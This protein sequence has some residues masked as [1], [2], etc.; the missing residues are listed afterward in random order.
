MLRFKD[1]INVGLFNATFNVRTFGTFKCNTECKG[2]SIKKSVWN[3]IIDSGDQYY[4]E[5]KDYFKNWIKVD[6]YNTIYKRL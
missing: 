2:Y 5:I 3:Q 1:K 6:F 4:H